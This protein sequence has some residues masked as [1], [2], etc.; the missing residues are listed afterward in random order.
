LLKLQKHSVSGET[1]WGV[2]NIK[3]VLSFYALQLLSY[4]WKVPN[5][6]AR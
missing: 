6:C 4:F 3:F 5:M 1:T 2:I